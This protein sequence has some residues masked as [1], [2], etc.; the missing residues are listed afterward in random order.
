MHKQQSMQLDAYAK[1]NL[2]QI[3]KFRD[4]P[5]SLQAHVRN[6]IKS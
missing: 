3:R 2:I 4:N 6:K 5:T 1:Q